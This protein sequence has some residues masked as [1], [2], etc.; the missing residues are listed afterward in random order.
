[1]KLVCLCN[2]L[3]IYYRHRWAPAWWQ[4]LKGFHEE[5][6]DVIAIPYTG[7]SFET[8]WWRAY[9]NPCNIEGQAFAAVKKLLGGGAPST[10]TSTG[11]TFNKT[12]IE[13]WVRPRWSDHL[14]RV[15]AE[16]R[17]V[18]AV[19]VFTIPV[20][21]FTGIPSGLR[22]R[23]GVPFFYYD[24][25]VP[26]SPPQFGE[27]SSEFNSYEAA[28]LSEYDGFMCNSAGGADELRAMG[29]QRVQTIHWGVDPSLY[30]PLACDQDW[31]VFF[32]GFGCENR[33]D[34]VKWMLTEPSEALANRRI[35]VSGR[36]FP[37]MFG[38]VEEISELPFNVLRQACGRSRINLNIARSAYSEVRESS[39]M[40]PFELAAMGC[41]I[42][43]NPHD[44]LETWLEPESEVL[45]VHSAE[46][47]I[48]TYRALLDDEA[49]RKVMGTAARERVL[50][51]HTHRHRVRAILEFIAGNSGGET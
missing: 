18:D 8:P 37:P 51:D 32:Y 7:A 47:A 38:R 22:K 43:S 50:R 46:E 23:F 11:T 30:E 26:A 45:V 41:C 13:A 4:F 48:E 15:L 12:M 16:E 21:H 31:D 49:R 17:N 29:A 14:G 19:I 28:D 9:S 34:W 5:G 1:M 44:G 35:C 10:E 6:H 24:G 2:S 25:D 39:T 3:D 33:E 36:G 27:T 40:R 20:N 42:V